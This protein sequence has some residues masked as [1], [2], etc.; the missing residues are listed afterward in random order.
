MS[1]I[2]KDH[3][4]R[5]EQARSLTNEVVSVLIRDYGA[6]ED[7]IDVGNLYYCVYGHLLSVVADGKPMKTAEQIASEQVDWL[8]PSAVGLEKPSDYWVKIHAKN[9]AE[10]EYDKWR[11]GK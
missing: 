3:V 1:K 8:I 6:T 5:V 2:V 4:A 11:N 7:W 9:R 10:V